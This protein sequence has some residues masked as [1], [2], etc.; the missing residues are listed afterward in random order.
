MKPR[1]GITCGTMEATTPGGVRRFHCPE[2][3]VKRVVEAGGFPLLLPTTDPSDAKRYL[4]LV[5]GLL[6]IGGDDV[7]PALYGE[8]RH[9]DLGVVD[10][11]RDEFESALARLA[12]DGQTPSLG[13]CRGL[14]LLNVALGGSLFQHVPAQVA[15]SLDHRGTHADVHHHVAV[16][17][18]SRLAK[19]IGSGSLEVNSFHHQA[20]ARP[21][22]RLR[23]VARS[24]D[25]VVE[26][27]EDSGHPFLVAV[28]WHP[29]RMPTADSS[30]R[31][32]RAFIDAAEARARAGRAPAAV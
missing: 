16:S 2:P 11:P 5:D 10:R 7:D 3:Y 6:L 21:A 12:A 31:L 23:V 4:G 32:F 15:G 9:P 29:E 13:I 24:A 28:Q 18:G 26:G 14:Q 19:A 1:I 8:D 25:G 27:V 17:P 20:I 22:T 30:R